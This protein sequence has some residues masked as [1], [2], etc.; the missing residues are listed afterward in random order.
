MLG[1]RTLNGEDY[2]AILKRRWWVVAIPAVLAPVAAVI[3]TYVLTP[4]YDSTSLILIDQQKVSTDVVKPLDI[5]NLETSL[6]RIT[7]QIESR[8]TMESLVTKYNLYANQHL[9]ME[10]RVEQ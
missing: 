5:G 1:H 2:L 8:S 3:S 10:A 4:K 9:S 7:A 6:A